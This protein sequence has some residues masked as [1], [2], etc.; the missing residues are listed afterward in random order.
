VRPGAEVAAL[1]R[2][3]ADEVERARRRDARVELLQRARG[4]VPRV[5][6][7]RQPGLLALAVH[8][9]ERL[10]RKV[11][12]AADLEQLRDAAPGLEPERDAA[13]R[14]D[15]RGDVLADE[16]VA[17]RRAD[18]QG[19]V[20]VHE[21]DRDPVD[22]RLAHVLDA[23]TAEELPD[24]LVERRELFA[25]RHVLEREH[26][27]AVARRLELRERRGPDPLRG[28]VGG[29]QLGML[30]F[31]LLEAAEERVVLGVGH[32]RVVEDVVAVVVLLDLAAQPLALV[33]GVA[34][35]GPSR[36]RR[37]SSSLTTLRHLL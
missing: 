13:D 25:R 6:E 16:P 9:A 14:P 24:A 5:R 17:A 2:P 11:D 7:D 1:A 35:R 28:R 18:V 21:L 4:G 30:V 22:L 12:L 34:R 27:M 31:Q 32:E 37:S 8:P 26:R 10:D 19:A 20:G 33:R 29:A 15:V 36:H 23:L 3:V